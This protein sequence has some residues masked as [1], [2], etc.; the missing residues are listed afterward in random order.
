MKREKL[1]SYTERA[2]RATEAGKLIPPI[3][4]LPRLLRSKSVL[5]QT[6][7][8]DTAAYRVAP[9]T[10]EDNVVRIQECDPLG[11]LIAV[12]HGQPIPEFRVTDTGNICLYYA[13]PKLQERMRA[14]E[15]LAAPKRGPKPGMKFGGASGNT[16]DEDD[17]HDAMIASRT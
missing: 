9:P 14:A 5:L 7:M 15:Y 10:V 2:I 3:V 8:P 17:A 4:Y 11:F 1:S 13:V 6:D 12:M 16:P